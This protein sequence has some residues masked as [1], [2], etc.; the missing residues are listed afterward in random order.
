MEV[1]GQVEEEYVEPAIDLQIPE[2]AQLAEILCNR[3][4]NLSPEKLLELRIQ[5]AKLMVTL[6]GKRETVRPDHIRRRVQ[7]HADVTVKEES[8]GKHAEQLGG[9]KQISCNHPKCKEE[10]LEFK[11]LNHFKNHVERVHGVRVRV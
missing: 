4:N 2:R 7:A 11:H 5:A 6:C 1:N 8:L 10:A 9:V 3:P